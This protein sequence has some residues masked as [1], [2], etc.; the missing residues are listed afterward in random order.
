MANEDDEA[1]K[2]ALLAH[3]LRTPL[4]AMRLTSELIATGPLTG[5]QAEQLS[6]LTNSIDALFDMTGDLIVE[7]LPGGI[8]DLQPVPLAALVQ[9]CTSLFR[10]AAQNKGL[11]LS[12][13]IGSG[14]EDVMT[15]QGAQIRRIVMT[16]L[17]NA[18]KY[19]GAGSIFVTLDLYRKGADELAGENGR[20]TAEDATFP[21]DRLSAEGAA[22]QVNISITDT[23]P[24]I[25]AEEQA[26]LFR[27]FARGELG[28][29]KAAGHGLG[30]WGAMQLVEQ[31]G[32]RM[33]VSQPNQG[34]T[35]FDIRLPVDKRATEADCN[36]NSAAAAP[37][38]GLRPGHILI[39]DDNET[40]CKLLAALLESFGLSTETALSG[41]SAVHSIGKVAYDAV[42]L[43]LHMPGMSGLETA[44]AI[45]ALP[46]GRALP[47]IA[48]T[49]AL[50]QV[51]D[52]Q[53]RQSGFQDA[54]AKP[55]SAN[56]LYK[57]L[58]RALMDRI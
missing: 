52:Q 57:A 30:L 45:R 35:R 58:E 1:V 39:V 4:A 56:E 5:R 26:R 24:G 44:E 18:V 47:L 14:V 3:D 15:P 33:T 42:L 37:S 20:S 28:R 55:I 11:A 23:G 38:Q 40:N 27:P 2:L 12:V 16:L 25:P 6:I 51:A 17:D 54:L 41:E 8:A 36:P 53:L 32:G 22:G 43:D 7:A 48:V 50:E 49:A 21:P 31:T 34:G 13:V 9:D 19:T 29:T 10:V 46:C